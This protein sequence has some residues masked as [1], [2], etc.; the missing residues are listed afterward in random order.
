MTVNVKLLEDKIKNGGLSK[1]DFARALGINSATVYRKIANGG[2]GF[3]VG[4]MHRTVD[5]LNLNDDEAV[6]IFLPSN[7]HKCEKIATN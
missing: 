2:I 6:Q 4:E 7:S 5:V 3:T 1:E